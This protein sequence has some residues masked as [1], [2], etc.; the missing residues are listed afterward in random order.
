MNS[1]LIGIDIADGALIGAKPIR[2]KLLPEYFKSSREQRETSVSLT[3]SPG[4]R[5][6]AGC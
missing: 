3:D 1:V 5:R 4:Q 2:I 6:A